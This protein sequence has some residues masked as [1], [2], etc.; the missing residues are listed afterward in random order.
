M[1]LSG[2]SGPSNNNLTRVNSMTQKLVEKNDKNNLN[3]NKNKENQGNISQSN[4]ESQLFNLL[5]KK[6]NSSSGGTNP[7][8]NNMNHLLNLQSGNNNNNNLQGKE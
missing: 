2:G 7:P 8:S 5:N 4:I 6:Q 3:G 1:S